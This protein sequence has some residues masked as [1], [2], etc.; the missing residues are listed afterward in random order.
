MK[1]DK[2]DCRNLDRALSLEW[3]ETNGR[4]GF[5]VRHSRGRKY[6]PV[7]CALADS[8]QTAK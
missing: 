1:V 2:E 8:A 7:S 6:P 4:G 5:C 3:L